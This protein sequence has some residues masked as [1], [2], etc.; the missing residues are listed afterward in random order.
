MSKKHNTTKAYAESLKNVFVNMFL[1][2][3]ELIWIPGFKKMHKTFATVKKTYLQ[4]L[5][6]S[7]IA[8]AEL[9]NYFKPVLCDFPQHN[10]SKACATYVFR[11]FANIKQGCNINVETVSTLVF[12]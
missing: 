2:S 6:L 7:I 10:S 12:R 11:Y 9:S 4:N 1:R 8:I 5:V 3:L